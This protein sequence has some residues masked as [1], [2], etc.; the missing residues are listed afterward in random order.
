[1]ALNSSFS[2]YHEATKPI[3][4]NPQATL[5]IRR[6]QFILLAENSTL[7]ESIMSY[8][9]TKNKDLDSMLETGPHVPETN[10]IMIRHSLGM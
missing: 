7:H 4:G 3:G 8:P 2:V 6:Y 9:R 10:A 5:T 1:M